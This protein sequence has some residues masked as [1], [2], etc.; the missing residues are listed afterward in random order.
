MIILRKVHFKCHNAILKEL[1]QKQAKLQQ[2]LTLARV[3]SVTKMCGIQ[4]IKD[5]RSYPVGRERML[6]SRVSI[7]Y[8]FLQFMAHKA[9]VALHRTIHSPSYMQLS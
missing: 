8:F 9:A 2:S 7:V 6:K 3:S 4:K 5:D 1:L